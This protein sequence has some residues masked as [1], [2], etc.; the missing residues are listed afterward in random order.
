M[1][2]PSLKD[3]AERAGVSVSTVSFVINNKARAMRI[4]EDKIKKVKEIVE[5]YG[6]KPNQIAQSLRT[7]STKTIG[8]IVEDIA[9]QFFSNLA[10][11]IEVE[12]KK[13]HYRVIYSSTDNYPQRASELIKLMSD[14]HVDGFIITP[15]EGLEKD[16]AD[17]VEMNTPVILVDRFYPD[18]KFSY[19]AMDNYHAA[20]QATEALIKKGYKNIGLVTNEMH[21]V[22]MEQRLDGYKSALKD[23]RIKV[24]GKLINAI[25]FHSSHD[26]ALQS[27]MEFIK[28]QKKMDAILF[29][30]NYLG[31]TGLEAI[32]NLG[33]NI[34][35]DIAVISIDDNDLFRLNSPSISV[36]K[37]P[38]ERMG[39]EAV[40]LL[41]ESIKSKKV[42]L[43]KRVIEKGELILRN[44]V[45]VKEVLPSRSK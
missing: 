1:K 31:I 12:A 40:R 42:L 20:Y 21:L 10:K 26:K 18:E 13:H 28:G 33:L 32:R 38:V 3:I 29:L 2:K 37:Q 11:V 39:S 9:N 14:T 15:T 5:K 27:M 30:T 34:P 41:I 35:S 4:S 7:G 43:N 25:K 22:Q 17:L 6:F 44:S 8:L 19:V 45:A 16:I 24:T 23:N 36:I